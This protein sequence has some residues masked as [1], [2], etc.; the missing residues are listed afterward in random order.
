MSAERRLT[1]EQRADLHYAGRARWL[2]VTLRRSGAQAFGIPSVKEPNT[3]YLCDGDG[4]TCPDFRFRGLSALRIGHAGDHLPCSHILAVKR[5]LNDAQAA[6]AE[7]PRLRLVT[8][9]EVA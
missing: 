6:L 7:A 3:F 9:N 5:V 4:C 8:G 2:R 1:R